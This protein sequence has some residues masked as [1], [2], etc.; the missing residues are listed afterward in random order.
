[1][2]VVVKLL[3]LKIYSRLGKKNVKYFDLGKA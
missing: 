2:F 1:M 3:S